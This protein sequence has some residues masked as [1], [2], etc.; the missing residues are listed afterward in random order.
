M[1]TEIREKQIVERK[2]IYVANDGSEFNDK[3]KCEEYE[4]S[5]E[6]TIRASFQKVP[7]TKISEWGL[8]D[9]WAGSEEYDV[10]L[11]KPRNLDDIRV[12]N[13]FFKLSGNDAYTQDD[14]GKE[15]CCG[16]DWD[17]CGYPWKNGIES[18]IKAIEKE[19]A[20]MREELENFG[21][22]EEKSENGTN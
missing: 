18:P 3:E 11:L 19:V 13:E 15:C 21:K 10:Y 2:T 12:M 20:R 1:R 5:W 4:K 9:G 7:H 14:I 8:F 17:G 16:T 22:P 6:C